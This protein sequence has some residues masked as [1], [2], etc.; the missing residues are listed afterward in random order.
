MGG[1][2]FKHCTTDHQEDYPDAVPQDCPCIT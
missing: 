2:T 1:D